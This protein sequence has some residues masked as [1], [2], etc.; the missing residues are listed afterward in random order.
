MGHYSKVVIQMTLGK[1]YDD[2]CFPA[3]LLH[4]SEVLRASSCCIHTNEG[5]VNVEF[6]PLGLEPER[7]CLETEPPGIKSN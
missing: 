7:N 2:A 6:S 4:T 5:I 1:V 3:Y